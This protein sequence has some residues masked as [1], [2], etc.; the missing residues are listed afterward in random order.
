MAT[1]ACDGI[2]WMQRVSCRVLGVLFR[3]SLRYPSIEQYACAWAAEW[4]WYG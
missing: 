2:I 3:V 4:V 1:V